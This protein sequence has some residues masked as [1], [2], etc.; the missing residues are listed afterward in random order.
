VKQ[1]AV[2]I[3]FSS[4][5]G[6]Y[7]YNEYTGNGLWRKLS[8]LLAEKSRD[9]AAVGKVFKTCVRMLDNCVNLWSQKNGPNNPICIHS[10]SHVTLN[11]T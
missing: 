4:D 2:Y 8:H 3:G 10:T 6:L 5:I 9:I 1:S 11:I 7:S